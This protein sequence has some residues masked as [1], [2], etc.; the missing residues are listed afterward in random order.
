MNEKSIDG[1]DISKTLSSEESLNNKAD[2]IPYVPSEETILQK[3]GEG[4]F[5][6][7]KKLNADLIEAKEYGNDS[8][9]FQIEE[10]IGRLEFIEKAVS[11]AQIAQQE[12][13]NA[14]MTVSDILAKRALMAQSKLDKWAENDSFPDDWEDT[15]RK[16]DLFGIA[17]D[18]LE[19][20]K[21]QKE[22]AGHYMI[23]PNK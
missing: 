5:E 16:R 4:I 9:Q 18:Q 22:Q 10:E 19:S 14:G 1:Q 6:N 2:Y 13:A 15:M 17:I 8:L 7:L 3:H 20:I 21:K 12:D 11:D 23:N